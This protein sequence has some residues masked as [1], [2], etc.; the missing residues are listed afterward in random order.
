MVRPSH[1]FQFVMSNQNIIIPLS[2]LL[3]IYKLFLSNIVSAVVLSIIYN[4]S[5]IGF[6]RQKNASSYRVE[7]HEVGGGGRDESHDA[8]DGHDAHGGA[9]AGGHH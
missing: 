3:M 9:P 8:P 7:F 4:L 5:N 2:V 1:L 6:Y